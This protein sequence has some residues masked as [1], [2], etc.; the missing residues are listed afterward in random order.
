MASLCEYNPY[1]VWDFHKVDGMS[2]NRWW[3]KLQDKRKHSITHKLHFVNEW[4]SLY[5]H[6][7]LTRLFVIS[8]GVNYQRWRILWFCYNLPVFD[9]LITANPCTWPIAAGSFFEKRE[10][11][12]ERERENLRIWVI[13]SSSLPCMPTWKEPHAWNLNPQEWQQK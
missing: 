2:S 6:H 4:W 13:T 12:R 8:V 11:E 9:F 5:T 10:R 3:C 7:L 1:I